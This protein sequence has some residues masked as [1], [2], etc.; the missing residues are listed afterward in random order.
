MPRSSAEDPPEL[1]D[2]RRV[3]GAEA[4]GRWNRWFAVRLAPGRD[5]SVSRGRAAGGS[6]ATNGAYFVRARPADF[7]RW[8][9]ADPLWSPPS[10][11]PLL[12]ALER[13]LDM[14]HEAGHGARGP[15]PVRRAGL[16]APG[17]AALVEAALD[18]GHAWEHDKNGATDEGVGAM[19]GNA[20]RGVR[21]SAGTAYLLDAVRRPNLAVRSG[22]AVLR[23]RCDRGRTTGVDLSDG[24]AVD[25]DLVV[26]AAGALTTPELLL[27]SGVGPAADLEA[28]GIPVLVDAPGVGAQLADHPQVVVSATPRR[29]LPAPQDGWAGA[30]LDADLGDAVAEVLQSLVPMAVLTGGGA[31][32][33]A[34]LPLLVSVHAPEAPGSLRLTGGGVRID[35]GYSRE[36]AD[37]RRLRE[38]V[39]LTADLLRRPAARALLDGPVGLEPRTLRDDAALDGWIAGRLGTALH[40]CSTVPFLLPDGSPGPVTADGRVRGVD[41]LVV[42]DTSILP[43]APSRGP[44]NTAVLIGELIARAIGG[45]G[46]AARASG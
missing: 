40:T 17:A 39:R 7:A 37:R 20:S 1:L 45:S 33:G 32:A 34:P 21:F 10:V 35:H 31:A 14:G 30:L 16:D 42:A 6:S 4:D 26:L 38:A 12:I 46:R 11:A 23:V 27:R 2:A 24:S 3:P 41:G 36:A 22:A 43:T 13:D 15:V 8:A 18:A 5:W 44:A 19:P 9:A 29:T 25:A 28:A